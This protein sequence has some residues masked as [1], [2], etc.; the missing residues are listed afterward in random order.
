MRAKINQPIG[1]SDAV[2][3][4]THSDSKWPYGDLSL[5]LASEADT[6]GDTCDKAGGDYSGCTN[7]TWQFGAFRGIMPW[8]HMM[9]VDLW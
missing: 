4:Y 5:V 2:A 9:Q 3:N 7:Y 6:T 8:Q 1:S